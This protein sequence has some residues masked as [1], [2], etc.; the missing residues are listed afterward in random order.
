MSNNARKL[1]NISFVRH[2]DLVG[3]Y[4]EQLQ[5]LRLITGA[6]R[7]IKPVEPVPDKVYYHRN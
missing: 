7:G 2:E 4:Y 3:V 5:G 6:F 1:G